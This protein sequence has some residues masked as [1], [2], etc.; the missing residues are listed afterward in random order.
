M[1]SRPLI[2]LVDDE[3]Q[4]LSLLLDALARRYG[5]DYRVTG[6]FSAH[7]ALEELNRAKS[8]GEQV[9]LVIADQW[10][11]EMKG[12]ELLGRAHQIH[13]DAQRALL[14]AWGDRS[15]A[16][17]ILAGCAFGQIENYLH[18]PWSPPEVHLY[19]LIG[20]YLAEWT[21]LHGPRM[22]LVRVIGNDPSPRAHEIQELLYR[23]GIPHGFYPASSEHG[24]RLLQQSGL[25]GSTLPVVIL[26]DGHVL[27]DPSN[28]DILDTLGSSNLEQT[29]CDVAVVGAG[30]AG[31]AAAVYAASEGL[32]TVVIE[33][34]AIGGQAGASALI[35]NYLGFPGGISGGDLMQRAYQQAWLFGAKY[36][37]A[38]EVQQLRASGTD[39]ILLLSDGRQITAR[40]VVI[41]SGASY[42]R[43]EVPNLQRLVGAGIYYTA[44]V[45]PMALK[46]KHVFVVGGGNSAGQAA[47]HLSKSAGKVTLILRAASLKEGMSDYLVREIANRSNVEVR[48]NTEIT[49]GDG[50][51]MLERLV[52]RNRV[53]EVGETVKADALFVLIGARPHTDWLRD[54]VKR[55]ERGYVVTGRDVGR[56]LDGEDKREPLPLETS[57]PGVFAVGDVRAGS[58]KRIASAVGEGAIAVQYIHAY[59]QHPVA[60]AVPKSPSPREARTAAKAV[61]QLA[62]GTSG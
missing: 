37:L 7:A 9:A 62:A 47:I 4:A 45:F 26:P 54:T 25:D 36:V 35:R 13:P 42:R 53:S 44:P 20:E 29:H 31:L 61:S 55:D 1:L 57:L 50:A 18:K 46:D 16:P 5:A 58:V 27:L 11:P 30:P 2:V 43:L 56:V 40:A 49:D 19:P 14:V 10:M 22:E 60:V 34:E 24:I 59:L 23:N 48:L 28:S 38:R 33:R 21:R 52:L 8:E 32:Q 39:R 17:T 3:P 15:A 51:H 12:I 6:H 41:A